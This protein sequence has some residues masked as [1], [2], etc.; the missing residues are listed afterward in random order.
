[1]L[2]IDPDIVSEIVNNRMVELIVFTCMDNHFHMTIREKM[3]GGTAKYMQRVLNAYTKYFNIRHEKSGHLF[4]NSYRSVHVQND[5]Q[6]LYLSAYSHKNIIELTDWKDHMVDYPWSSFQ[7]YAVCNRWGLLLV[8]DVILDK[9][10]N[11][12][13]YKKFVETG[14]AKT[15]QKKKK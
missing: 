9:F 10:S 6:L 3:E 1:M 4:Q 8:T 7:D 15:I 14:M 5:D 2:T 12:L 11:G 13:E